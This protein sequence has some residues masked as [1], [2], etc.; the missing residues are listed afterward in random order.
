MG[1]SGAAAATIISQGLI[2][3]S[4][5]I[6]LNK[7]HPI[8]QFSLKNITFDREIFKQCFK[9]GMPSGIQQTLVALSAMFI[10]GIV[11]KFGTDVIAAYSVA[12]RIDSLAS[13]PAMNFAAALTTFVGQNIGANKLYRITAGY[14]ATFII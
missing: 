5:I 11:N 12:I 8:I 7:K 6:Y 1:V 13:L 4:S 3:I 14:R 2:F 10:V 9:I